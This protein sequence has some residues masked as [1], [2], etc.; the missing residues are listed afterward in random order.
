MVLN[1]L[2]LILERISRSVFEFSTAQSTTMR[3]SRRGSGGPKLP[4]KITKI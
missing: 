3:G 1:T 4:E 2:Q